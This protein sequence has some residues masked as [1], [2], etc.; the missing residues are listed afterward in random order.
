[1]DGTLVHTHT[2]SMHTHTLSHS[3]HTRTATRAGTSMQGGH[4][5]TP[6]TAMHRCIPS[7]PTHIITRPRAAQS[8]TGNCLDEHL[9]SAAAAMGATLTAD[10][11]RLE[12][13]G[14]GSLDLSALPDKLFAVE[15]ASLAAGVAAQLARRSPDGRADEATLLEATL[16]GVAGVE[17]AY[18]RDSAPASGARSA[19]VSLLQAQVAQLDAK[20]GGDVTYQ[21]AA[22]SAPALGRGASGAADVMGWKVGRCTRVC[23]APACARRL[24]QPRLVH[25]TEHAPSSPPPAGLPLT[26]STLISPA[27]LHACRSPLQGGRAPRA[28]RRRAVA[29][30]RPGGRVEEV[31]VQG[32]RVRRL[33]RRALLLAR[34]GLV[35]GLHAV[36]AGGWS[37]Q[38]G[39]DLSPPSLA[40]F[41]PLSS[42]PT[43]SPRSHTPSTVCL[44]QDTLLFGGGRKHE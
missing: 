38:G 43:P 23:R 29:S 6:Y 30:G 11:S 33:P 25:A 18:G 7:H 31:R 37:T 10:G 39:W 36:Q 14:G 35:H 28:A 15:A 44:A 27:P 2:H 19:L 20:Y 21:A 4:A 5:H 22:F 12:L 41:L 3:T 34:R 9:A 40:L 13:P 32:G 8:C 16:V 1:V 26:L 24:P 42:L 17:A